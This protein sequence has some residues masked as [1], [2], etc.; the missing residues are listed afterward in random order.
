MICRLF[1]D[2]GGDETDEVS[3]IYLVELIF[4]EVKLLEVVDVDEIDFL[5]IIVVGIESGNSMSLI[6][7]IAFSW[8]LLKL[9]VMSW[10]NLIQSTFSS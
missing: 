6:R 2:A 1:K 9:R 8:W 5:Q 7:M 10:R 4:V 3:Q